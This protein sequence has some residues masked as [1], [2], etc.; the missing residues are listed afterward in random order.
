MASIWA[1][2]W[3]NLFMPYV[4][5]KGADQLCASAQSDQRQISLRISTVWSA[6]LLFAAW[7]DNTSTCYRR[8]FKTLVSLCSWAGRLSLNWMQTPKTGFLVTKL[9]LYSAYHKNLCT[10]SK[11]FWAMESVFFVCFLFSFLYWK[12]RCKWVKHELFFY[13]RLGP[14]LHRLLLGIL[15]RPDTTHQPVQLHIAILKPPPQL[16]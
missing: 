6:P 12:Y 14:L 13:C 11:I 10:V 1:M 15:H 7:I 4:N 8:N 3:E 9:L 16:Q 2:S 5:N